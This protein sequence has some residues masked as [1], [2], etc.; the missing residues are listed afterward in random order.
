MIVGRKC[1]VAKILDLRK[2]LEEQLAVQKKWV[3]IASDNEAS[4]GTVDPD[5]PFKIREI[6]SGVTE[7]APLTRQERIGSGWQDYTITRLERLSGPSPIY[8]WSE[9]VARAITSCLFNKG[10]SPDRMCLS[11]ATTLKP[12][13]FYSYF[14]ILFY[15]HFWARQIFIARSVTLFVTDLLGDQTTSFTR[16]YVFAWLLYLLPGKSL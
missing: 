12:E 14:S 8:W 15:L 3:L 11:A 16:I 5:I 9:F 6:D 10:Q 2:R 1:R 13:L 7:G 4:E